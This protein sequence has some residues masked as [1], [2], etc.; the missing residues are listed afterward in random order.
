MAQ[1]IPLLAVCLV[2]VL[3]GCGGS[4][5]DGAASGADATPA[6]ETTGSGLAA[7]QKR[8]SRADSLRLVAWAKTFRSCMVKRGVALGE[9]VATLHE[10]AMSLPV[11]GEA[12]MDRAVACG[13]QLGG[14]PSDSSLQTQ[15]TRIVLYLPRQCLLDEKVARDLN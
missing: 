14:P 7:N 8:L 15:E 13:D 10:I 6:T 9:P 12:V 5:L 11:D 4:E 2:L 1:R 3:A